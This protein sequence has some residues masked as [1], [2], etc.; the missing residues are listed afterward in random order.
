M[1]ALQVNGNTDIYESHNGFSAPVQA[2]SETVRWEQE[3]QRRS[4]RDSLHFAVDGVR[5]D[6]SAVLLIARHLTLTVVQGLQSSSTQ[7]GMHS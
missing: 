1:L 2:R 5:C 3:S 7:S 6:L 4:R